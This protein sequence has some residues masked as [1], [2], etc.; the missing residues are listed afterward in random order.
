M[1]NYSSFA[2]YSE[3]SVVPIQLYQRMLIPETENGV[4]TMGIVESLSLP[5]VFN[6]LQAFIGA[7]GHRRRS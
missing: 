1:A 2:Q 5:Q 3:T 4:T 7:Q 6:D